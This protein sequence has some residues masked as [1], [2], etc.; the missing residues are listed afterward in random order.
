MFNGTYKHKQ[1]GKLK[2]IKLEII[3]DRGVEQN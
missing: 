1:I 3:T 2:G